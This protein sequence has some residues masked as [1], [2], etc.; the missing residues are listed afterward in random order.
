ML[1]LAALLLASLAFAGPSYVPPAGGAGGAPTADQLP[2]A[3]TL[4][5]AAIAADQNDYS[6]GTLTAISVARIDPDAHVALTG[7][8]GGSAGYRLQVCNVDTTYR[9]Q[10]ADQSAS[11][12]AANRIDT[13]DAAGLAIQPGAC[14]DLVYD[15]TSSRWRAPVSSPEV[16]VVLAS[17]F[18]ENANTT[19]DVTGMSCDTVSGGT[20][21][22]NVVGDWDTAATTTGLQWTITSTGASGSFWAVVP[23]GSTLTTNRLEAITAGTLAAGTAAA[24]T[25]GN[26]MW[27][28]AVVTSVGNVIKLRARSEIAA[29]AVTLKAGRVVM[30]CRRV[31]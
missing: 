29:S 4:S 7:I 9:V 8:S 21:L 25:A 26:P 17:D 14:A 6:V 30:T 3:T 18:V 1:R 12:S 16:V 15:G 5:P 10:L 2:G 22:V 24:A 19:T 27:G 13:Q 23:S 11:S 28:S 31:A 20:Y